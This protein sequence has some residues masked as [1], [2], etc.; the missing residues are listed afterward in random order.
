MVYRLLENIEEAKDKVVYNHFDADKNNTIKSQNVRKVKN[1]LDKIL[2]KSDLYNNNDFFTTLQSYKSQNIGLEDRIKDIRSQFLTFASNV[3]QCDK[4][5]NE[6]IS[7]IW[8]EMLNLNSQIKCNNSNHN[9]ELSGH[10]LSNFH[11]RN[12]SL[13]VPIPSSFKINAKFKAHVNSKPSLPTQSPSR[14]KIQ[15][16]NTKFRQN[17]QF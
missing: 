9:V 16:N 7:D 2:Q 6:Q 4:I 5:I 12:T 8:H 15:I 17:G 3:K 13:D 11:S 1:S 14:Q 10:D